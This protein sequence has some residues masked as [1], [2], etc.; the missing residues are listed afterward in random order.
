[1]ISLHVSG[2]SSGLKYEN[3]TGFQFIT[4]WQLLKAIILSDP[5]LRFECMFVHLRLCW[6]V[7]LAIIW[8]TH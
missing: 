4:H 6:K 7:V 3:K 2:K 8:N 5:T 1:M